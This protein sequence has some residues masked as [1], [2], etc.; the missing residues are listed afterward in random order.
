MDASK[1]NI[2]ML[3]AVAT[4][5]GEELLASVA[6]VGG[7]TTSLLLTDDFTKE[8][9]RYT[10]DVDLI[11]DVVGRAGWHQ[12][13]EQLRARGFRNDQ[14]VICRMILDGLKVDFMPDDAA[15]LGFTNRWYRDAVATAQPHQ[16][17]D[18]LEIRLV[19]PPYFVA[20]KLEAYRGRGNNDPLASHDVEDVL[21]LVDGRPAIVR[22]VREAEHGLRHYIA[23][24]IRM[25]LSDPSFEYAVQS[26]SLGNTPR[27]ELL[28]ERLVALGD[29][30]R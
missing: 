11:V 22:E 2:A 24:Q 30:S 1:Q 21:N 25:L 9:V 19:T 8:R 3:S 15:V 7:S 13:E 27:E 6:F 12:F 18:A 26:A 4:A 14:D 10:D 16:L 17:T 5:L 20:T 23:E 29:A 28:L